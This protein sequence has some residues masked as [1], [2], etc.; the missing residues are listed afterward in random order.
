MA[1]KVVLKDVV[2]KITKM[3]NIRKPQEETASKAGKKA[4]TRGF[5]G[6]RKKELAKKATPQESV[7]K[8]AKVTKPKVVKPKVVSKPAS[9][10]PKKAKVLEEI[11]S[12]VTS[13]EQAQE[14]RKIEE[15]K[16][17]IGVPHNAEAQ[18][19]Y[20][21][22]F[23]YHKDRAVVL[24]VDPRFVFTYWEIKQESIH[25]AMARLGHRAKLTLR[26]YDVS[27]TGNPEASPS[28]D[29]EVFDRLGNWYLRLDYPEQHLCM[30]VGMKNEFGHFHR[31]ARSN[32]IKLPRQFLAQPGPLKWMV[33]SP[34]G[35]KVITDVEEYTDAD[36]ELLRKILGP[37]FFDLL[38]KGQFASIAGSSLEAIFQE[39]SAFRIPM[40]ISSSPS[41]WS[42]AR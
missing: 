28:W 16:F 41:S 25:E 30:D 34:D 4:K 13:S 37:Y 3:L 18:P 17:D 15:S 29:I 36:L 19:S 39:I 31:I 20:D 9:P 14:E 40:E 21:I 42:G 24:T 33:V 8:I 5:F 35:Q 7:K 26:F 6:A 10:K 11:I 12:K 2:K 1:K 27:A 23:Q 32:Y 22:P 38:M